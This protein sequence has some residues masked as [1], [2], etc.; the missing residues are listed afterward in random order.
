MFL[1][2]LAISSTLLLSLLSATAQAGDQLRICET[3]NSYTDYCNAAL[4]GI[5]APTTDIVSV[6]NPK[7]GHMLNFKIVVEIEPGAPVIKYVEAATITSNEYQMAAQATSGY[8]SLLSFFD[9]TKEIPPSLAGSVFDVIGNSQKQNALSD[10]YNATITSGQTWSLYWSAIGS[11]GSTLAHI[12]FTVDIVFPG[13]SRAVMRLSGINSPTSSRLFYLA[14]MESYDTVG[15]RVP[16]TNGEFDYRRND[17]FYA[18]T[19]EAMHQ[20]LELANRY[21]TPY[22]LFTP[23][24][25]KGGGRVRFTECPAE[26]DC[27]KLK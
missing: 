26:D 3:C 21:N 15:N 1:R 13:G 14:L 10:Y 12:A 25:Y 7:N 20:L 4:Q 8:A 11:L 23:E 9:T 16:Q 2:Y 18:P 17:M 19:A 24:S 27:L 6:L 5:T 22:L